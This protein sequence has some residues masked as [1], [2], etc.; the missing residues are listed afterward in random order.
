MKEKISDLPLIHF[1]QIY[2]E[3]FERTNTLQE[4]F[5]CV[6]NSSFDCFLVHLKYEKYIKKGYLNLIWSSKNLKNYEEQIAKMKRKSKHVIFNS[7]F[8]FFNYLL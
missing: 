6:F 7:I 8:I 4:F 5:L 1:K 3:N 2:F